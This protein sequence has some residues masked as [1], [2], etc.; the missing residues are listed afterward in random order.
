ME[1]AF[2]QHPS[3]RRIFS[4]NIARTTYGTGTGQHNKV[5]EAGIANQVVS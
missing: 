1:A 3:W 2:G 4:E 5:D